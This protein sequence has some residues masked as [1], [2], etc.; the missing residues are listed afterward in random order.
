M[1][2]THKRPRYMMIWLYL[3]ILTVAEVGLA[4]ELPISQNLKLLGLLVL[5]V[6]KAALVALFFMHLKFEKWGLRIIAISALP[7]AAIFILAAMSEKIW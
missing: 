4:L 7:L 2:T 3:A 1:D 6:W 5:A